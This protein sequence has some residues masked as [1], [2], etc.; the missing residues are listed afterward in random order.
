MPP[1]D[2]QIHWDWIKWPFWRLVHVKFNVVLAQWY[3]MVHVLHH[4][5][6]HTTL[7]LMYC[8]PY[9]RVGISHTSWST[10]HPVSTSP[11]VSSCTSQMPLGQVHDICTIPH[12]LMTVG[13]GSVYTKPCSSYKYDIL[14]QTVLQL[15]FQTQ[16]IYVGLKTFSSAL[17]LSTNHKKQHIAI[18]R[19]DPSS[20][21]P[22]RYDS[23]SWFHISYR[24][25]LSN[26][27][28][29]KCMMCPGAVL[30]GN[31]ASMHLQ[32]SFSPPAQLIRGCL[33]HLCSILHLFLFIYALIFVSNL[34]CQN[35]CYTKPGF[36][37]KRTYPP[38]S[39]ELGG[40]L[41]AVWDLLH[42]KI[43][44]QADPNLQ[45][46]DDSPQ[47]VFH[48]EH[49]LWLL[50]L[51]LDFEQDWSYLLPHPILTFGVQRWRFISLVGCTWLRRM[52]PYPW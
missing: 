20:K 27:F 13:L 16:N 40:A 48:T 9:I 12:I 36:L 47:D 33:Q 39:P 46:L 2:T 5:T 44:Q 3:G 29:M 17:W 41:I 35:L 11:V 14:G 7:S 49:A 43:W 18:H 30:E 19:M 31:Q 22:W 38:P 28:Y 52:F 26:M 25:V 6:R 24:D 34:P 4:I 21:V 1:L 50:M 51:H 8:V 10:S 15:K 32:Q 45:C 37:I 23:T 42:L